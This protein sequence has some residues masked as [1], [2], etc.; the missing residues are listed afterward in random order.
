[1]ELNSAGTLSIR[2][3]RADGSVNTPEMV[4]PPIVTVR[5]DGLADYSLFYSQPFQVFCRT[6][7]TV[8]AV[9]P[10]RVSVPDRVIFRSDGAI[11]QFHDGAFEITKVEYASQGTYGF[12]SIDET[13]TEIP[14]YQDSHTWR[15]PITKNDFMVVYYRDDGSHYTN[16]SQKGWGTLGEKYL[17]HQYKYYVKV[18]SGTVVK[19]NNTDNWNMSA[20]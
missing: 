11:P 7:M 8:T 1:M 19:T 9:N 13:W 2:Y 6:G 18:T 12:E 5:I 3:K 4:V 14:Y 16:D 17:S 15:V 20:N 10:W